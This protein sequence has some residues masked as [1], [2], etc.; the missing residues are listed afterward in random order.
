MSR[1]T[2]KGDWLRVGTSVINNPSALKVSRDVQGYESDLVHGEGGPRTPKLL[3][4]VSQVTARALTAEWRADAAQGAEPGGPWAGI[5]VVAQKP[6]RHLLLRV[7]PD[8]FQYQ[9]GT[10]G[11][12]QY[13]SNVEHEQLLLL[14]LCLCLEN[15][16]S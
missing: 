13:A 12:A 8:L 14:L 16:E 5:A 7:C 10:E 6:T 11:T 15:Q 1:C 3:V 2:P 4:S 9:R